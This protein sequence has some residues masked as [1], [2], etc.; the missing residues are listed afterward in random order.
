M[1]LTKLKTGTVVLLTVGFLGATTG[2]L[3][4]QGLASGPAPQAVK[5]PPKEQGKPDKAEVRGVVK[6]VDAAQNAITVAL[7]VAKGEPAVDKTF[8]VEKNAP[9]SIDDGKAKDKAKPAALGDVPLGATVTL[10]LGPGQKS[11]VAVR[12]EGTTVHGSVRAVDVARNTITLG[13]KGG[14]DRTYAVPK[15]AAVFLDGKGTAKALADVPADAAVE[16]KLLADQKTVREV[17]ASGPTVQGAVSGT[18]DGDKITLGNKEGEKTYAL[19]KGLPITI[20][21]KGAGKPA[22][23]ID[24]TVARLR[25]SVDKSAVLA[26]QAEGPSFHGT[27]KEVGPAKNSVTLTVGGKNGVGGEEKTFPLTKDTAVV[28]ALNGTAR[29]VAD[30]KAG[31]I[32]NLRLSIDQKAAARITV[33]GE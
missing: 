32:V 20:E 2:W 27:L 25:L 12:A 8:A 7:S 10:R 14:A 21:G 15:D 3:T 23:L 5:E 1:L 28:T 18:V 16:L 9:V 29:K 19:A 4:R 24:G 31:Q 26:I 17:R 13:S 11:V 6:V 33:Q 30:L 22:D